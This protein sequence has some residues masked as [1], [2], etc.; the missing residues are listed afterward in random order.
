MSLHFNHNKDNLNQAVTDDTGLTPNA[1][2]GSKELME[3]VSGELKSSQIIERL[4]RVIRDD[5]VSA[6]LMIT[7]GSLIIN[8][9]Y[10]AQS[11]RKSGGFFSKLI[12]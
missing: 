8:Q 3:L 4:Y 1:H 10:E 12:S 9:M 7:L 6:S 5:K 2:D 11:P